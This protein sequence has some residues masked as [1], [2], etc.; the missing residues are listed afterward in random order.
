MHVSESL[1]AFLYTLYVFLII[2]ICCGILVFL[3]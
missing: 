1:D 3:I 2:F